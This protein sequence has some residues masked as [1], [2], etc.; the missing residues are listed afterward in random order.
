MTLA[1]FSIDEFTKVTGARLH[2]GERESLI[3]GVTSDSRR[4]ASGDMFVAIAGERVDGH[5]FVP[6][7][8][9][10]GARA[11]LIAHLS[12]EIDAALS[13]GRSAI[14]CGDPVISTGAMA[15]HYR[16]KFPVRVV[17]VTGSVG[18]TTTKDMIASVLGTTFTTLKNEGNLNTEIGVPLTLFRLR[19]EH[20]V[21]VIEMAMRGSGQ[22]AYLAG[23]S[24]PSVGVITNIGETHLEVMGSVENTARAKAELLAVLPPDG[25]AVLNRDNPW[26]VKVG[27]RHPGNKVWYSVQEHADVCA[28]DIESLSDKGM[29]FTVVTGQGMLRMSEPLPGYHNVSNALASVALGLVFGVPLERI[30]AGL[31]DLVATGARSEVIDMGGF[32]LIN[33]TYNASPASTRA[34]LSVLKDIA[35]G[36][37][38]VA[39]LGNMLELGAYTR[40]GHVEVGESI[41][42]HRVDVL[43]AVG[44]LAQDVA[45]AARKMGHKNALLAQDNEEA[46]ATLLDLVRPGDVV[47]VKG[48]RGVHMEDIVLRLKAHFGAGGKGHEL[49]I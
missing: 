10:K 14:I 5:S 47:L 25:T 32:R 39:V 49:H 4:I 26:V 29:E 21:A 1:L 22:I 42:K 9:A 31:L 28:T 33:D 41:V 48:S 40:L 43:L 6:Q 44:D 24:G 36:R 45:R 17:G 46:A 38:S 3:E 12:P 16:Q 11:A 8:F 37:R 23:L 7:A 34:A 2:Y 35:K 20:Q 18:K 15:R 13:P 27:E 30:R 19:K